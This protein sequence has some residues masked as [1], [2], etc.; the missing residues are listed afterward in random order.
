MCTETSGHA[1]DMKLFAS[2]TTL[3]GVPDRGATLVLNTYNV[4]DVDIIVTLKVIF[5]PTSSIHKEIVVCVVIRAAQWT[6][7]MR[8][9]QL[10]SAVVVLRRHCYQ[11]QQA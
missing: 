10:F 11:T 7:S 3:Q 6:K 4:T 2:G 8:Q 1:E 5:Q 9:V